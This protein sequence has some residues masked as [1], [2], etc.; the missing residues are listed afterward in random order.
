MIENNTAISVSITDNLQ[1]GAIGINKDDKTIE[2]L[3]LESP[4]EKTA[5]EIANVVIK[6]IWE[7]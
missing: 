7:K 2:W 6:A 5:I 1:H 4:D 3:V